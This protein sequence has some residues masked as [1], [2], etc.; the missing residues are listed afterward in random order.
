MQGMS[1][2]PL[3]DKCGEV[4]G[5]NTQGLA[6][7]SLFINADWAKNNMANFTDEDIVKIEVD[8]ALSPEDAVYAFY[9]Y[10]KAR[11]MEDGFNL[12]ILRGN[13]GNGTGR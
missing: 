2:G 10:L 1:G 7:P 6:G 12:L 4:V 11:R 13:L 3:V 9:T 8:P 5:I